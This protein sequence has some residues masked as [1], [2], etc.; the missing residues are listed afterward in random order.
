[1]AQGAPAGHLRKTAQGAPAEY[2]APLPAP[3]AT[4]HSHPAPHPAAPSTPCH[5]ALPPSHRGHLP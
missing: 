5:A 1:M 4:P 3:Q 2:Q